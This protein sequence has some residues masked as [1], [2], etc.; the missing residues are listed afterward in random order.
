[1]QD[2]IL[3]SLLN[4]CR[5]NSVLIIQSWLRGRLRYFAAKRSG[6]DIIICMCAEYN[7]AERLKRQGLLS[8]LF[9]TKELLLSGKDQGI[10]VCLLFL[11]I[12][13]NTACLD[14]TKELLHCVWNQGTQI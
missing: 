6:K 14:A 8:Q 9:E 1:V 2:K 3:A 12:L 10:Y 5:L 11:L 7:E 13:P 4:S